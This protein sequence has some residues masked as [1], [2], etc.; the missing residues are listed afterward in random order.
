MNGHHNY[1]T[2]SHRGNNMRQVHKVSEEKLEEIKEAFNLFDT[3][4]DGK[5]DYFEVKVAMRALGF[6]PKKDEVIRMIQRYGFE[7][8]SQ[9]GLEGFVKVVSEKISTLDPVEEYK[10]AFRLIDE[11][12]TG[13]IKVHN[14]R[15]IAKE[16]GETISEDELVAMIE[17]FDLDN[18]G[19]INEE[20]FIKIMMRGH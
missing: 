2:A 20:E 6:D 12:N 7:D 8:S 13:M 4:R 15:R 5:I 3:N 11:G 10:K 19:G 14:L 18:D 9:M 16:L 17:E 1:N